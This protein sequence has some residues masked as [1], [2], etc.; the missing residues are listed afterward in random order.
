MKEHEEETGQ[1]TE[2]WREKHADIMT[3]DEEDL[4]KQKEGK[5][6]EEKT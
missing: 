4:R 3:P 5:E 2:Q 1:L 6:E